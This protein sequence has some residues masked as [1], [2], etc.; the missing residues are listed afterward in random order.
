MLEGR[1]EGEEVDI[2]TS[3]RSKFCERRGANELSGLV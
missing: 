3:A 2:W 1:R